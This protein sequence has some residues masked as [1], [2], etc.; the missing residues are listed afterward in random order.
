MRL[1]GFTGTSG[2][3]EQAQQSG[4]PEDGQSGQ[5]APSAKR[6][7]DAKETRGEALT[8]PYIP[9]SAGPRDCL[10]QRFGMTEVSHPSS[11]TTHHK[12]VPHESPLQSS[13]S[14]PMNGL[15]LRMCDATC[16]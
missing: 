11:L 10:G 1:Y 8:R 9:F 15:W 12:V 14:G 16:F 4:Q 3:A 5:P 6:R 13:C 2:L 7:R